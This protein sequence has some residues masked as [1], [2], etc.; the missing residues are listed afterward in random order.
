MPKPQEGESQSEFVS[1]CI[2]EVRGEG[3]PQDQAVAMC[4]DIWSNKKKSIMDIIKSIFG[5]KPDTFT[6]P[7]FTL[8]KMSDGTYRWLAIFSNKYRDEDCPPEILSE[9]AH[10]DFVKAIDDGAYP[11]PE[12]WLFHIP[13]TRW[14]IT[15]LV[16]YDTANGFSLAAGTVDKGKEAVAEALNS[17]PPEKVGVS[18]GMPREE[19][20]RDETDTSVLVRYRS[21]EISPLPLAMAANKLT[22]FGVKEMEI[23]KEKEEKLREQWGDKLVDS[24]SEFLDLKGVQA[25]ELNMEFKEEEKEPV[26]AEVEAE[27]E[28]AV[29]TE[30]PVEEVK[31][32]ATEVEPEPVLTKEE[33]A[34]AISFMTDNLTKAYQETMTPLMERIATLE[35]EVAHLKSTDEEK[36]AEKAAWTT[37][38]AG[39]SLRDML[40]GS[41]I[42]K[43]EA[44]IDG[45]TKEA[46]GPKE[47]EIR[48]EYTGNPI[49]DLALANTESSWEKGMFVNQ[50]LFN[51]QE[52]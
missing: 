26:E 24:I 1:R 8:H 16:A 14:G 4:N 20:L 28:E 33:V 39:P 37:R 36:V 17:L 42:G 32:D 29:E 50:G 23:T 15:E 51:T 9:A 6:I 25:K 10:L 34:D 2:S 30:T 49:I 35:A 44:R 3:K 21:K 47:A 7:R 5:K 19:I 12:L 13:G 45:R 22:S 27:T 41:I 48:K 38:A 52:R 18:H 40:A 31:E 43:E 46:K 11:L